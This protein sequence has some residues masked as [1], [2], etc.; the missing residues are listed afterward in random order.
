MKPRAPENLTVH[1][2]TSH[3][4]QLTWSDPYPSDSYLSS[5]LFYQVNISNKDDPTDV[6]GRC[7]GSAPP[8]GTHGWR[9]RPQGGRW[10]GWLGRQQPWGP[11]VPASALTLCWAGPSTRQALM[12]SVQRRRV[13]SGPCF[14]SVREGSEPC[15]FPRGQDIGIFGGTSATQLND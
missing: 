13:I 12:L 9:L 10:G 5:G 4:W 7:R 1:N 8:L 3:T 15:L 2:S 14:S 11:R 6:S